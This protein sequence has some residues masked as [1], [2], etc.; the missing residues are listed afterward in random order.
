MAG[1]GKDVI[2]G[3]SVILYIVAGL[4]SSPD[5]SVQMG[6]AFSNRDAK[7]SSVFKG[8]LLLDIV[9]GAMVI[10]W[11]SDCPFS[12]KLEYVLDVLWRKLEPWDNKFFAYFSE[13]QT[14]RCK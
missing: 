6:A 9:C 14:G 3:T 8:S 4:G 5:I 11:I 13:S 7:V 12:T 1:F 2:S 10:E